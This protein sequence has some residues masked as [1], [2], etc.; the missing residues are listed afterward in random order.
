LAKNISQIQ[1]WGTSRG[2]LGLLQLGLKGNAMACPDTRVCPCS[3][4]QRV[5]STFYL[6]QHIF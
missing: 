1:I 2:Q 3:Y 5:A 4:G 6:L